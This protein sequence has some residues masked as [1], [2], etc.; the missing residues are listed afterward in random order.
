MQGFFT[1]VNNSWA[2]TAFHTVFFA[3]PVLLR[4]FGIKMPPIEATMHFGGVYGDLTTFLLARKLRKLIPQRSIRRSHEIGV[5]PHGT[6]SL[7]VRK[8]FPTL[9][10]S[11][12]TISPQE[13]VRSQHI[14]AMNDCPY[15]CVESDVLERVS[16]QFDIIWW[17]LPYYEPDV[18]ACIDRLCRQSREK[19]MLTPNGCVLLGFNTLPLK[20][21]AV[22]DVAQKHPHLRLLEVETYAWN[23]HALVLLEHKETA[24]A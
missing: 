6:L 2:K 19:D 1:W 20:P 14:A 11:A 18:L 5:G 8:R 10:H 7:Y 12:S 3:N 21:D 4:M 13:I 16:G 15:D 9:V 23:P 24:A 22:L 17:N